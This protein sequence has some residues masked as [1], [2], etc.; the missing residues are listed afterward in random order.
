[1]LDCSIATHFILL[2]K[3]FKFGTFSSDF[4]R[5]RKREND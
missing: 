5:E 1:M 4:N 2:A 3:R